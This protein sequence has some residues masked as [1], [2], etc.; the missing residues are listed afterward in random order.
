MKLSNFALKAALLAGLVM[1][2][3]VEGSA[4]AENSPM[5]PNIG[6]A[7]V[8]LVIETLDGTLHQNIYF[9]PGSAAL[10]QPASLLLN[11]IAADLEG[12]NLANIALYDG[13]DTLDQARVRVVAEHLEQSG[14][15]AAWVHLETATVAVNML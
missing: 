15:P 3:I 8:E 10:S 4:R 5:E 13:L 7:S 9:S 2:G 14:L 12:I 1:T 6:P 11:E